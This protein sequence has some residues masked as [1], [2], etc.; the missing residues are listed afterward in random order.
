MYPGD[1]AKPK[2]QSLSGL[3]LGLNVC[4]AVRRRIRYKR[5]NPF[6]GCHWV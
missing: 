6:Q 3:S 4:D 5:F 2:F 1:T